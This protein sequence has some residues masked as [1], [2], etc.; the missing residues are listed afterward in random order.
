VGVAIHASLY[1]TCA[2]TQKFCAQAGEIKPDG[3]D[4]SHPIPKPDFVTVTES[5][6]L[7]GLASVIPPRPNFD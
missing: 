4:S 6:C 3:I 1:S 2:N 5:L 7:L